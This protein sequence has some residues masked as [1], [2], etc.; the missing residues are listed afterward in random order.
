MANFQCLVSKYPTGEQQRLIFIDNGDGTFTLTTADSTETYPSKASD[1]AAGSALKVGAV[2]G[3]AGADTQVQFNNAGALAGDPDFRFIQSGDRL[4][5]ALAAEI[6]FGANSLKYTNTVGPAF[7]DATTGL[8][9][10]FDVQSFTDSR[11]FVLPDSAITFVGI[12]LGAVSF[13]AD[14]KLTA[15]GNGVYVKEGA[16]ATMGSAVLVAGAVTVNTT[17]VTANS[18][19]LLTSQVDGGIPGFLR[20]SSRIVGTS[21]T[22]TSSNAADTSTV[23]WLIVE[24]A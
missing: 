8:T 18:R 20:I 11:I 14:L 9:A 13:A 7:D 15:A 4:I 5:L 22:V 21:F 1:I 24:P 6:A 2:T 23:A 12:A 3:A 17:K 10:T 16:N 19:I